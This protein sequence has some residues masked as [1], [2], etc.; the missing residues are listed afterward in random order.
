MTKPDDH[1][2]KILFVEVNEMKIVIY[3][4]CI[5][6]FKKIINLM[7]KLNFFF[8]KIKKFI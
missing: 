2:Q 7:M 1:L 5:D 3:D 6:F 4:I 8:K